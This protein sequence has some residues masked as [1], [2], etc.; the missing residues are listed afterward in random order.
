MT[1]HH[2]ADL[3]GADVE[4]RRHLAEQTMQAQI[5]R[6]EQAS[7]LLDGERGVDGRSD[8]GRFSQI[9]LDRVD[10]CEMNDHAISSSEST[11]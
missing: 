5:L 4:R 10:A 6:Q 3:A 7:A 9:V 1:N 2:V 11:R 8:N